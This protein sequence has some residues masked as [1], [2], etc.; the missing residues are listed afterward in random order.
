MRVKIE[1][2]QKEHEK[3]VG[4]TTCEYSTLLS[5]FW[6][7]WTI[8]VQSKITKINIVID[9]EN[10]LRKER[11]QRVMRHM[12]MKEFKYFN[13]LMI[14][15]SVYGKQGTELWSKTNGVP[16]IRQTLSLGI[17][18][19]KYMKEWRFKEIKQFVPIVVGDELIKEED[20]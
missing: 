4:I 20:D 16:K 6:R 5:V 12:N 7:S 17:D 9:V 10:I 18:F 13:V 14:G 11:Y 3:K 2:E 8:E 1:A 15:A 19:G